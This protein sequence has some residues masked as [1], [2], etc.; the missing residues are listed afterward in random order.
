VRCVFTRKVCSFSTDGAFCTTESY[1][2]IAKHQV[3]SYWTFDGINLK[4]KDRKVTSQKPIDPKKLP[5]SILP[6]AF[7][8]ELLVGGDVLPFVCGTVKENAQKL[9]EFLGEFIGVFPPPEFKDI[10]LVGII[11]NQGKNTYKAQYLCFEFTNNLIS[12]VK[13]A[14]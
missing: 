6:Y 8:E 13:K 1:L 3:T 4:E 5:Q 7:L 10:S 12:N 2:D 11:Y 14:D 9:K